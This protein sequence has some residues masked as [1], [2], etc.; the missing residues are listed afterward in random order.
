MIDK[1]KWNIDWMTFEKV[2]LGVKKKTMY[3][4]CLV[5][6]KRQA[7]IMPHSLS[8]SSKQLLNLTDAAERT[9]YVFG[10]NLR[11]PDKLWSRSRA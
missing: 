2:N 6:K 11:A 7:L 1:S 9:R 10:I 8:F 4:F 5:I 3:S